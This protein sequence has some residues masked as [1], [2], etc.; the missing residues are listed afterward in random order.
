MAA[1]TRRSYAG[2]APACTLTNSITAGDTTAL[3]TGTVT[4]WNS[5]ATGPFFM[6]IDPGLVTE[7]KVLV[8][9]RTGS[10][11][12]VMTRGVDG[13]TAA[14]HSAGATCYPVFTASDADEANTLASVMTTRGDII[15][16]GTGPT[17]ARLAI[18]TTGYA[19]ISDGTDP[20]WG[21]I[22]T[23]GITNLA[24]T[25]TKRAND[26]VSTKTASYTLIAADRNTKVVMNAGATNTAITVNTSLFAAGD[27][28]QILNTSTSGICTV[29]A[30]TATVASAG[31]LALGLNQ[32][33]TLYFTSAGVSVFQA[34]GVSST[35]PTSR[36]W[37]H[38][39]NGYGSSSTTI[40]RYT[41]TV[42]N[43]GSDITYA[44]SASLGSTFTI[45][46]AGMYAMTQSMAGPNLGY[47]EIGLSLNSAQ[48]TTNT[49]SITAATRLG[50]SFAD[51]S[52]CTT[53]ST[54]YLAVNDVVR[55]HNSTAAIPAI[56]SRA[57]FQIV[58][59][60]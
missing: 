35:A 56:A 17:V 54:V 44:D 41:T 49:S 45:N 20:A 47:T 48:L 11:L 19:L 8:G 24:V 6:V 38:T 52:W 42:V 12:S 28:L 21:Q 14:S 13:T 27:T 53:T 29:T 34:D 1:V 10:S 39:H 50:C 46:T 33:G 25:G 59:V 40:P 32:G 16:M 15:K 3:L 30:G 7:E 2:A 37:L 26:T 5:T 9:T 60:N 43:S 58:R 22:D 23:A 36:I 55:P 57:Q 51:G 18:G 31:S 4:A